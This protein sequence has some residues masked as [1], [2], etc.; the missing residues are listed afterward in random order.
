MKIDLNNDKIDDGY[1]PRCSV[2]NSEFQQD[3]EN[4]RENNETLESIKEFLFTNGV[5]ISL[6]ALSRHFNRH[7][8][9][10]KLYI[11]QIA[12]K[13]D[14]LNKEV[15]L[16]IDEIL[17]QHLN[18]DKNYFEE[19]TAF[20]RTDNNGNVEHL[21]KCNKEIFME[22]Y[23]F[24][25]ECI[26]LCPFIPNKEA[27]CPEEIEKYYENKYNGSNSIKLNCIECKME[28]QEHRIMFLASILSQI[29]L[30]SFEGE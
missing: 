10:R 11:R 1:E 3:I 20:I 26:Q 14:Q 16:K 23:G 5:D 7:Y 21:D 8:P 24:C 13:K 19:T 6:M 2:C 18:L 17:E 29:L 15:G 25:H 30:N 22:D 4:M 12:Y 28:L 27:W 9:Q